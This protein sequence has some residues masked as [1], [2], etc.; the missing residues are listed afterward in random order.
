MPTLDDV[1]QDYMNYWY[2]AMHSMT[3]IDA[4]VA[5]LDENKYYH[6]QAQDL[7]EL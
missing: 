2:S 7:A 1:H 5:F 3:A 6:L 4:A